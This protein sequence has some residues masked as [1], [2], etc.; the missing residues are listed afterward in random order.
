[1]RLH[2]YKRG[3]IWWVRGSED[4]HKVRK[5]TRHES[6]ALAGK[7][8]DRWE[9]ELADPAHHRANTATIDSAAERFMNE[10]RVESKSA[11]TVRFYDVKVRH[12]RRLL[13]STKLAKLTTEKILAY[14]KRR[15][16]EGAHQHSVFHERGALIRI[17]KSAKRAGDWSGDVSVLVPRYADGYVPSKDWRTPEEVWAAIRH[18]EPHRGAAVAFCVATASD[19][20]NIFTAQPEDV[21]AGFTWVRGTKSG[22]RKRQVPRVPLFDQFLLYAVEHGRKE[23]GRPMFDAWGNM[24]RD[25]RR[26]CKRAG[27]AGFTARTL[28]HSA[29]TW[30]VRAGVPYELAAAFLGH[31]STAMLRKVYGH[32]APEDAGRLIAERTGAFWTVP[33][34]Y[35]TPSK[36]ADSADAK[37]TGPA[38]NNTKHDRG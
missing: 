21:E 22:Y 24:P 18:L 3:R 20:S 30:M 9:K 6:K 11:G 2:L 8:R 4:G 1:M 16:E 13:G 25:L 37:D 12:V 7:V 38:R 5:S 27:V 29:A 28:R 36:T 33:V 14:I 17:L 10:L 19:F 31:G 23:H 34:V 15:E 35:P 26:A 32:M